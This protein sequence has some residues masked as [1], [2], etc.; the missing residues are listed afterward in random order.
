MTWDTGND[1]ELDFANT[2]VVQYPSIHYVANE[3]K[4]GERHI[5][6][7]RDNR[8]RH[9]GSRDWYGVETHKDV[10]RL[11]ETGWKEGADR[12]IE[13]I[14][15]L[16]V[17]DLFL[18]SR[19]RKRV[20]ADS[21]DTLDMQ[22]LWNGQLDTAWHTTAKAV[23]RGKSRATVTIL[24]EMT[25]PHYV[26]SHEFFWRGAASLVLTKALE[27]S[28]RRVKIIAYNYTTS[29]FHDTPDNKTNLFSSIVCK[30]TSERLD[31]E[32]VATLLCLGGSLRHYFFK[33]K[34]SFGDRGLHGSYGYCCG[35]IP[36]NLPDVDRSDTIVINGI[37]D[38]SSCL[39]KI[40]EEIKKFRSPSPTS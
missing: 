40:N 9:D 34:E 35:E 28:G 13:T 7:H 36:T 6:R 8:E 37:W 11:A 4:I 31:I 1:S 10:E 19:R 39:G 5:K 38:Q 32:R 21:G 25:A 26:D 3:L 18:P 12:A 14:K 24:C 23:S 17:K 20:F 22:R 16:N 2:I 33:I 30:N 29:T 27:E 15:S